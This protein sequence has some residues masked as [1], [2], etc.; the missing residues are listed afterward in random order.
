MTQAKKGNVVKVQ[1]ACSLTDGTLIESSEEKNPIEFTIGEN[2]YIPGF[3]NAVEGM[4]PGDSKTVTVPP[5]QAFGTHREEFVIDV[6]KKLLPDDIA[7][8]VGKKIDVPVKGGGARSMTITG[9]TDT[10]VTL[11]ANHPLAGEDL[12]FH[13]ELIEIV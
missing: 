6:D 7:P 11:D 5:E 1:F 10:Q 13:I 12:I 4:H 2:K 8:D 3:E 9:V